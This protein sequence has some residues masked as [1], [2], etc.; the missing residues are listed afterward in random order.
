MSND[1]GVEVLTSRFFLGRRMSF[2]GGI[3]VMILLLDCTD[4]NPH[5]LKSSRKLLHVETECHLP[6]HCLE[7]CIVLI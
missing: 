1:V 2:D 4:C 3:V 7:I 5:G 6:L